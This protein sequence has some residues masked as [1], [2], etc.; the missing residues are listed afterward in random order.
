MT[1]TYNINDL[2]LMLRDA[3]EQDP[4]NAKAQLNAMLLQ[5]VST[6]DQ[7]NPD[8]T[9]VM[10]IKAMAMALT[11][12]TSILGLDLPPYTAPADVMVL[13]SNFQKIDDFGGEMKLFIDS[14]SAEQ[15]AYFNSA[16]EGVTTV[17]QALDAHEANKANGG[18]WLSFAPDLVATDANFTYAVRGGYYTTIGDFIFYSFSLRVTNASTSGA[19]GA[20]TLSMP[21]PGVGGVFWQSISGYGSLSGSNV[22]AHTL[23]T[24]GVVAID[25]LTTSTEL[26]ASMLS[27]GTYAL[28]GQ[29]FYRY[30]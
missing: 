26:L 28:R 17:N 23:G 2:V 14:L 21:A 24:N 15:V 25:T 10:A 9:Q 13:N 30:K 16:M 7:S 20:V 6:L 8:Q 22:I 5:S 29:I 4:D 18:G 3:I 1:D 19:T 11:D 12:S 27:G